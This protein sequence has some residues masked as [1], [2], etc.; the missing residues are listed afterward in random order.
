MTTA[1]A[2]NEHIHSPASP[3]VNI[4]AYKFVSLHNLPTLRLSLREMTRDVGLKGTILLSEEGI[5]LFVA[6]SYEAVE[7]LLD[8][9]GQIPELSDLEVKRSFSDTQPFR[10]MLV[11]VKKEIIAFGIKS[12][13][14]GR[15]TSR[16]ISPTELCQWLDAQKDVTLLDVRNDY[17]VRLGTFENAVP[18]GVGQ[19]R[20]FAQ[21]VGDMEP[22]N[23]ARPVVMFCTGGIRCEKAGP[24]LESLGFEQVYQLDGG[25][26][27]YFEACR[28]RHYR[29]DCF[30]FD[31]RVALDPQL[32]ETKAVLCFACR[33]PLSV[34]DQ[35]SDRYVP[36]RHCPYCYLE[37]EAQRVRQLQRRQRKLATVVTPLPG[38]QPYTNRRF[39]T[40]PRD[41]DGLTL[42]EYVQRRFPFHRPAAWMRRIDEGHVRRGG[43]VAAANSILR[44]GD[45]IENIFPET[46]EPQVNSAIQLIHEDE[47]IVVANKPAPL[48]MHACGRF[49][50]NSLVWML[51]RVYFPQKL[52]VAHRLDANTTGVVVLSRTRNVARLIQ[53]QFESGQI[54]KLYL[55]LISGSPAWDSLSCTAPIGKKPDRV[56]ARYV[57]QAHGLT[58]ISQF[59]VL[60][61]FNNQT[62]L[63][64]IR[65]T[66]GRTNQIRIH[67]WHL[68]MPIVGDPTYLPGGQLGN[69]QT[70]EL[71]ASPMC[72][73]AA[74]LTFRHPRDGQVTFEAPWP[75]W[76]QRHASAV[77]S[78]RPATWSE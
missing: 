65:P 35:Q 4:A 11:K 20:N 17:E 53:P 33:A 25:I 55:A 1:E 29:G 28:G 18:V 46:V 23:F 61:R 58:A 48:P 49:N 70:L 59:S 44:Q 63:V 30:V 72:L 57:V 39:F 31:Q 62:T 75:E 50:R 54:E 69:Q 43:V 73:H 3:V 32:R 22:S 74:S 27:K 67:A 26:L 2:S 64:A 45:R 52:H 76:A 15:Y 56:G 77:N 7:C 24:Y 5:N 6:G 19:F 36:D 47:F 37:P 9:L 34:E 12:I 60:Q 14:P 41:A 68:G 38:S 10:R 40:V 66:T 42:L 21:A 16:K 71:N 78:R 8:F 13:Q 51:N